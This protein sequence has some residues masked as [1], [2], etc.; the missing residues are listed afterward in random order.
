[1]G[2]FHRSG[3]FRVKA[4]KYYGPTIMV[5][6]P[7][8]EAV[9]RQEAMEVVVVVEVEVEEVVEVVEVEQIASTE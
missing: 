5:C 3:F 8:E 4:V 7:Q 6:I 9:E 2:N 1:M